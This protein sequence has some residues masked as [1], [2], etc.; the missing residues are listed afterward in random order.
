[1]K[2]QN[3]QKGI[4][5]LLI[6]AIIAV[7]GIAGGVY[8][9]MSKNSTPK[10]EKEVKMEEPT[11]TVAPTETKEESMEK[12]GNIVAVEVS[13]SNYKFAPSTIK[14]K[15]GDTIKV[16]FKNTGGNHDFRIDEFNVSTKVIGNGQSE[17][18]E[19]KVDKAG[20]Y[21]YY[22]SVGQHRKMGMEGT[23]MVE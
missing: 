22:C 6:V 10:T 21:K 18:V 2:L 9:S 13:G 11:T 5:A 1:M 16:T 19:F 17:T 14:A 23:L 8:Y 20:S 7:I 4:S 3:S 15:V 12:T